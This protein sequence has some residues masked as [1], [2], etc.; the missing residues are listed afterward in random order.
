M[1]KHHSKINCDVLPPPSL[2]QMKS[3][4]GGDFNN[5]LNGLFKIDTFLI[6]FLAK[7]AIFA[8]LGLLLLLASVKRWK[9]EHTTFREGISHYEM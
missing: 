8:F 7:F 1:T 3:N 9:E 4:N 5:L 2:Q 6:T